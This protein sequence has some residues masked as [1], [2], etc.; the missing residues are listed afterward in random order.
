MCFSLLAFDRLR[1]FN[2]QMA[3]ELNRSLAKVYSQVV[4]NQWGESQTGWLI[5]S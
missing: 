3:N 2:T 4:S 5:H 1:L